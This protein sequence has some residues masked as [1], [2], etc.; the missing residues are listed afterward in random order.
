M[1]KPLVTNAANEDQI[2]EAEVK[3]ADTREQEL[4][5]IRYILAS[6]QGRRFMWR[7]LGQ[8]YENQDT[9]DTNALLQSFKSGKRNVGLFLKAEI[10]SASEDAYLKMMKE[11]KENKL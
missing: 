9:F 8:C 5:D 1:Q 2:K 6:H 3:V 11:S 10:I 7:V 4:D